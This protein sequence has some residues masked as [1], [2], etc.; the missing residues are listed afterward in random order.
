MKLNLSKLNPRSPR[1]Y[2]PLIF[3]TLIVIGIMFRLL[4]PLPQPT[5]TYQNIRPNI[6][7][8]ADL[9]AVLGNPISQDTINGKTSLQFTSD[10][11][12]DPHVAI[13]DD[14]EVTLLI[15]KTKLTE[16][17]NIRDL[18]PKLGRPAA[19]L[20]TDYLGPYYPVYIFPSHGIALGTHQVSG[21]VVEIWY[22]TPTTLQ[23]FQ[24]LSPY[25]LTTTPPGID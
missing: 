16:D 6:S 9:I 22:F 2:T 8:P 18:T 7:T 14:N 3:I 10:Y 15:Q 24:T 19:T 17:T 21:K 20:Y 12:Q 23:E 4:T 5:L 13:V 1:F 25:L 11:V